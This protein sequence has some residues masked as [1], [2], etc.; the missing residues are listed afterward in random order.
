MPTSSRLKNR[1]HKNPLSLALATALLLPVGA[2]YAQDTANNAEQTTE[3]KE[4]TTAPKATTTLQ[5]VTVTGSRIAKDTFNSVSPVQFITREETTL[6]GFNSTAAVLQSNTVTGG[7]EQINNAFGGYVTDG[8]PGANTLSLRGLGPTRTLLLLNGRRIAPA[9]SRGSVGSADLNVL[10]NIMVDRTEILKDGASSIYG[11][12]AVAGVVNIITKTKVDGATVEFQHNATQNGGGDETRWSALMG[13]TGNNWWVSGSFEI[14]DRSEMT[15][16]DKDWASKCPLPLYGRRA[17]GSYGADDYIDPVTGEPKCWGLDAGGVTINT[18]GTAYLLGRPGLGNLGYYGTYAPEVL[19]SLGGFDYFN[20]WR[21]NASITDGDLPGFEG[22]D[23]FGRD[24]YDPRMKQESLISPT[25]NYTGFLQGGVDLNA[26]GDAELYFELLATRRESRQTGYL[27]HTIDYAAGNPLLGA[28]SFLPAFAAAPA[29]GSTNGRPIAARAFVGWGLYDNWQEVDFF[30]AT[31]GLRGNLGAEWNYDAYLSHARS[32]ADYY[33][34][35]RLTDRYAKSLDVVSDGNGG[36]VCRDTSDGCVAAPM[37]TAATLRGELPQAYRDYIMQVTH[38]N[39]VYT[40]STFNLGVNGPLFDLPYGS[41][42]G[43]FGVE[44]R[45][46]E[47]DDTPDPNSVANNLYGFT[48]SQPT[49]GKDSVQEAFAE[50]EFPLLSGLPGAEELTVNLSGRYTDYDSYGDDTTWKIGMLYTP[51]SWLSFRASRGTSFRAP[52]LFEQ[53]LGATSGFTASSG[54]PCNNWAS[55][56]G[57][58]R[59][60]CASLGLPN[61]FQQNNS[62]TVLTRGGAETGLSAETSTALTAG[63]I[64]QPEF[65]EW[66]GDLSF[67][68]DYYDVQVNNGVARPSG[69]QVLNL[70]YGSSPADFNAG[71]GFCNLVV[72]NANNTLNVTTGYINVATD[73]VRGWDF[74]ARYVR[75]IGQG[76]FRATAMVS[77]YLEQLG[78]TFPTDPVRDYA[79]SLNS[80]EFTGQL[81]LSY[82]LRNWRVRYGLDWVDAI[83]GY[84]YYEKYFDTDYRDTYQMETDHYFLH[85]ASVQYS[86]DDWAITGGIRNI[87]DKEPPRISTSGATNMIG[88]APLYSGVDYFGRTFFVNFTKD[89]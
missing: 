22:V 56:T 49:R 21:P 42:N 35:N 31:T 11:S 81:N 19:P 61:N 59:D 71:T 84:E 53:Y 70:C 48:A 12:D 25:T 20:R 62:I 41:V 47:I 2:A 50:V 88:N 29:D 7:S 80:P 82:K 55:K 63:V 64:I 15:L 18:L 68:A 77:H 9:G 51:V 43:A 45:R 6:A 3:T 33:T 89:F 37:L 52:A 16:G 30:R 28:Y 46:A 74:T 14:Y 39:T 8:G 72:R 38:G 58:V 79:G 86:G 36:F 57:N 73:K 66:F 1:P 83:N 69:A 78:Q 44:Y 5:S 17:D 40:E 4:E 87:A 26:M 32:E 27:Q 34:E 75:D 13:K 23:Y 76:E 65:P 85:S 24:T 54:D 10:P 67:A 60:N